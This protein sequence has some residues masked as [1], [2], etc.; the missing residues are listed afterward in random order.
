MN[1]IDNFVL[2][3]K[4]FQNPISL[5]TVTLPKIPFLSLSLTTNILK[6]LSLARYALKQIQPKSEKSSLSPLL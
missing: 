6:I 2:N 5:V 1:T 4:K 3:I